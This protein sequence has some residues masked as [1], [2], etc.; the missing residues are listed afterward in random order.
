MRYWILALMALWVAQPLPALATQ[1]QEVVSP[2]GIKAWLVEEHALPL[3]ATTIAFTES[4]SA[5]DP[6]GKEGLTAMV[7]ALLLEGAGDLDSRAFNEALENHAIQLNFASDE[8][9]FRA[10]VQSLSEH[11]EKAFGLLSLALENPRFDEEAIERVRSQT[12]SVLKQQEQEPAYN[13]HR[14]WEKLAFG[15]HP[16]GQPTLGTKDS[17]AAIAKPD[18]I[19]FTKH[20]ISRQNMVIAVVGD[21][22]PAELKPL[23]D[24]H[25]GKLAEHYTP[26]KKVADV[27]LRE[28][29]KQVVT[30][31]DIP[32]AMVLFGMNG[33]K[34]EHPDYYAAH[35]MNQIIGGSGLTSRLGIEIRQKR[36]LAYS[37]SSHLEPMS[38]SAA[39]R[40]SFSTRN[41]KAGEALNVLR[42]TLRDFSKNG[43]TDKEMDDARTHVIGSFM[44]GLDS[45]ADIANFLLNMQINQ[46]GM[47][48]FDKRNSY[49]EAVT[50]EQVKTLAKT[51][52][53][54]DKLLVVIVGKPDLD[55][56]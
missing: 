7:A 20:Y 17:V 12:L 33:L 24:K 44:L 31:F 56:K 34:R 26:D 15:A 11:K 39:W 18:F 42:D 8:D 25:L 16:Y 29:S 14:Q 41:E 38:H 37:V 53:D 50:K 55:A 52:L 30:E 1:V 48:Y 21:M 4:G 19:H 54:P 40:G 45:N 36:G 2:G 22:T 51:L 3:V 13:A 49:F 35:I 6:E 46:L 32:Q 10:Q 23:L 43:P 28:A 27:R 9:R 5:F 47:D